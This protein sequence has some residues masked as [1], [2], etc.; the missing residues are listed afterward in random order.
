[1]RINEYKCLDD[2]INEYNGKREIGD[3]FH[4]GLEFKYKGIHYRI[5]RESYDPLM[6]IFYTMG[7][8][9]EKIPVGNIFIYMPVKI[10]IFRCYSMEEVLETK[11]ID[12]RPFKDVIMDDNTLMLS[13]D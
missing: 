6:F 10:E 2:F 7:P 5:C 3:E 9:E 13:K 11:T 12:N 4:M 1:M 8:E